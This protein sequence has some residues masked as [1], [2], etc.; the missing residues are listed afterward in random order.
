VND[1]HR[2]TPVAV[3]FSEDRQRL[4]DYAHGHGKAVHR[5]IRD[6]VRAWL[7][8]HATPLRD[9]RET[10]DANADLRASLR[11]AAHQTTEND[12]ETTT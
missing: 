6:A 2:E 10:G 8:Q 12:G 5:V 4:E 11:G 3:R 7:D 9:A 1:R